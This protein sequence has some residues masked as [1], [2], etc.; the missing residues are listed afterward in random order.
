MVSIEAE[1]LCL[2][3]DSFYVEPPDILVTLKEPDIT[4]ITRNPH[5][6]P[7]WTLGGKIRDLKGTRKE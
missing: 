5:P 3:T 4:T 1:H 7:P 2:T 6:S